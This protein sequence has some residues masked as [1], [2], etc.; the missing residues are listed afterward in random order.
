MEERLHKVL[1]AAGVA[2]RREAERLIAAGQVAV[3]GKTV[4]EMGVKV[5]P[6][7]HAI[8]VAGRPVTIPRRKTYVLLN[9]PGGYVTTRADP[10]A[11]RTVMDLLRDLDVPVHPVG[12]LDKDTEGAL[13]VTNDGELTQL[14]T[15]PRHG[16]P[17]IYQA[18]VQGV[19]DE[20]ALEA[21]RTGVRLED[22]LTA[23]AQVRLLYA[24]EDRAVLEITLHE[25]RKRQV[26]RMLDAVGH[27][28]RYLRRVAIG[29][30]SV[31]KL[32]LGAWRYLTQKEV[33]A[34]MRMAKG[35]V[36]P[37]AAMP[38]PQGGAAARPGKAPQRRAA[39]APAKNLASHSAAPKERDG[40]GQSGDGAGGRLA[41][42]RD[43][44]MSGRPRDA[45][46]P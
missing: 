21:L 35:E 46:N 34:L 6:E 39:R 42:R 9:K 19:P 43:G 27:P 37:Q 14:L 36:T 1:A 33:H 23:P 24:G 44:R 10:H 40:S 7:K 31:R 13:I 25:G 2:S 30:V 8:S 15:H 20:K 3:D 16:V 38:R 41:P 29:P 17:K 26:R 4:T 11:G 18:H 5:D 28:V 22:G 32:P 12:R 45:R